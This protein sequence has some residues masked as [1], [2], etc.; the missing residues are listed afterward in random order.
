M[1]NFKKV[2]LFFILSLAFSAFVLSPKAKAASFDAGRII[3]DAIFTNKSAMTVSGIQDFLNSKVPTCDTWHVAGPSAQGATPP[4]TCLKNY[5][6]NTSTGANNLNGAAIPSG[7]ISAAQI[8]YDAAQT[9]NLNPQ[10]LLVT[11]QKENGLI[12]DDWPYPWQYR[13]A[14]GFACPDN[15]S[16]D[17]AY[18]GFYKQVNQAARHFRNFYDL[19]PSWYIPFRPG[20]NYIQWN[21]NAACG[22][23]NVNIQN[24]ATAALYSYTPYQPNAAALNNLYGTGDGCSAYGNRNFWRDFNNWFGSTISA[25]YLW[26]HQSTSSS[27]SLSALVPG[28]IASITVNVKNVGS[29]TWYRDGSNQVNLAT[30]PGGRTSI[31]QGS[32]WINAVTPAKLNQASVAPGQTGSFTFNISIP[33]Y[34]GTFN[35]SFTLVAQGITF[36]NDPG[37]NIQLTIPSEYRWSFNSQAAYTD[38]SKT[39]PVDLNN[40]S[41][42]Q[43]AWLVIKANNTGSATWYNSGSFPI[44]LVTDRALARQ[45]IFADPTWIN[46]S[47]PAGMVEASVA[48]GQVGTFEFKITAPPGT[49]SVREYFSLIA[50]GK[51]FFNADVGQF[52][53]IKVNQDFRWQFAG[54]SAFTNSSKATQVNLNNMSPGQTAWLQVRARN[55]GSSSWVNYGPNAV[56]LA[57]DRTPARQSRFKDATWASNVVPASLLESVV[58]PGQTGTFEFQISIP[59]GGGYYRE[60]FN[61]LAEGITFF[62]SD[63]GQFFGINVNQDYRWEFYSQE[64]FSD[65]SKAA[66]VNL[67]NMSPGQT[68]W[69][70]VKAKNI[71]LSTWY[72]SGANSVKLA[73]DRTPARLSRFKSPGW[74]SNVVPSILL[75]PSVAPGQVGTFEFPILVPAG[76]GSYREYFNPLAEGI[77]FFNTNVGQFFLISVQ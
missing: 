47:T 63:V 12:T 62:N 29:S 74:V 26:E 28:D 77:T 17:P 70:Q 4:W 8:I 18:Y 54:Q 45:S 7:A 42:G 25:P 66:S 37:F 72:N 24:S 31:F 30:N 21:P 67:T 53:Q 35:E 56:K 32:G 48:P 49:R 71:G 69:L 11:L 19:N 59:A 16:C 39:L 60:Y 51:I 65:S 43:S 64:S 2:A 34:Q 6:E 68:A 52:F 27:K 46:S 23:T 36:F 15:G 61:P 76:A 73:T 58:P 10:V 5:Y 40:M 9:Y 33:P 38:S 20:T 13:T 1:K 44:T 57:T 75:E 55:I 50:Q 14:M 41:P 3:D 22:G